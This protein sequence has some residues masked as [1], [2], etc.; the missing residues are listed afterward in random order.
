M[1][2]TIVI[3]I[4]L[5]VGMVFMAYTFMRTIKVYDNISL[6]TKTIEEYGLDIEALTAK[7]ELNRKTISR[8]EMVAVEG[9]SP[10]GLN[11]ILKD[12]KESYVPDVIRYEVDS[13]A[14]M[15]G[16]DQVIIYKEGD[17]GIRP[18]AIFD[19]DE[20]SAIMKEEAKLEGDGS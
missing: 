14:G 3:L 7:H 15:S 13:L 19:F 9:E 12:G 1:K 16:K 2:T 11:I 4:L 17:K 8:L 5:V 6:L 18:S 20:V 10:F